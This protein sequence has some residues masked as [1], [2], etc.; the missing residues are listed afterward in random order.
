MTRSELT[1]RYCLFLV[2][3]A[4]GGSS[5]SIVAKANLGITPISSLVYVWSLHSPLTLGQTTFIFNIALIL[6][7]YFFIEYGIRRFI[8]NSFLQLPVLFLFS[9]AID[10][11][12]FL[13]D[14]ILPS[15]R[16]YLFSLA[17]LVFGTV[18]LA[19]GICLQLIA[20]VAMVSGEAFVNAVSKF[21]NKSFGTIKIMFDVSLVVSAIVLSLICT[22]FDTIEGVREGTIFAAFSI[23]FL[24]RLMLPHLLFLKKVFKFSY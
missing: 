1:R 11:A 20:N 12:S 19:F 8:I 14:M 3:V 9:F 17:M 18:Y 16:S 22:G 5:I 7:Q 6:L 15:E 10:I 2:A 23:G 13:L 24:V 4:I 21:F